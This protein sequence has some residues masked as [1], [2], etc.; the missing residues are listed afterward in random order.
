MFW[1]KFFC[2]NHI[3]KYHSTMYLNLLHCYCKEDIYC[4]VAGRMAIRLSG[5]LTKGH[6]GTSC[7]AKSSKYKLSLLNN[8]I[9]FVPSFQNGHIPRCTFM[10][11][12][13]S[14]MSTC[15]TVVGSIVC[16][17]IAIELICIFNL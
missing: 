8:T 13:T 11:V 10:A 1:G 3:V 9:H 7:C 12:S 4:S 5:L 2:K 17:C 14:Y 15:C 6:L 16:P